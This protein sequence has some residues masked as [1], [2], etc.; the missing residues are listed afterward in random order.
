M[1]P[2][3]GMD[4]GKMM[5]GGQMG[6]M[7]NCPMMGGT[8]KSLD[9]IKAELGITDAQASVWNAFA[10]VQG[11]S[12]AGMQDMHKTMMKMMDSTSPVERLDTHVDTMDKHLASLKSIQAPLKA[13]YAALSDDQKKKAA[14]AL[15]HVGCMM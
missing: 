7:G 15:G 8:T 6:M 12:Q 11:K 14:A 10:A 5:Q 13:L 1:E 9:A 2:G 4:M 3:K